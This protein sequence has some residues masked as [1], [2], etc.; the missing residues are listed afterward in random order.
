MPKHVKS[1]YSS[2]E[3]ARHRSS[4]SNARRHTAKAVAKREAER[5]KAAAKESEA[6]AKAEAKA[7]EAAAK[8]EAK[9]AKAAAK[10]SEAAA[11]AAAEGM[12][13]TSRRCVD[14][15]H[16]NGPGTAARYSEAQCKRYCPPGSAS[17]LCGTC[18]GQ[19]GNPKLW[20]GV[21]GGPLPPYSHIRLPGHPL[22]NW[23]VRTRAKEQAKA[24]RAT[25]RRSSSAGSNRKTSSNKGAGGGGGD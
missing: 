25:R 19:V 24:N 12:R 22:T 11:K 8:A 5:A 17:P 15:S 4:G 2:S 9:A 3:G 13:C 14:P 16:P 21:M 7:A 20:H 1:H 10:A 18:E 23:N 6:A